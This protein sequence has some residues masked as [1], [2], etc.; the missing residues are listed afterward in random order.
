M[1]NTLGNAIRLT[2]FGESHGEEIGAVIDGLPAGLP[3]DEDL[4]NAMLSRRRPAGAISTARC[5][6]DPWRVVS[7][8]FRG[9]TTGTPLCLLIPNG[10][11]KSG[12]YEEL[13][14]RPRP[15]HADY[16]GLVKYRGFGDYRG[17]GNFSGR[18]TAPLTA[19]GALLVGALRAKGV[20]VAAHIYSVGEI[21]DS[22]F[23]PTAEELERAR[24]GFPTVDET[25]GKAMEAY[26]E[27]AAAEGDSIGGI[28]EVAVTGVPAGVGEPWFGGVESQ[29]SAALFAIPAVKG[30]EF[31]AGFDITRMKGSQA[32]DSFGVSEGRVVTLS[33]NNGGI[34]GGISNGMPIVFRIAV[35][36][37]PSIYKEQN[38]L[39]LRTMES[40][41]L[42]IKGRHDPAIV[43]RAVPVAEAV[44]A[45]VVADLL[46]C[47]YGSE[48][49][50]TE[51]GC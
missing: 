40:E 19:A 17:G 32:N 27:S 28:I 23:T 35:K 51:E 11:T 36:P 12:D 20:D 44:S 42:R 39:N 8:V 14:Y 33:N 45:L 29:L 48:W 16:T 13:T 9:H 46:A 2:L 18:L 25:A 26:M 38:T 10:D 5:E 24:R 43:H 4:V 3:I 1:G 49:L 30:V 37:T 31:G 41:P 47:R 34:N 21:K 6:T 50:V 7:G 22:P 15:G